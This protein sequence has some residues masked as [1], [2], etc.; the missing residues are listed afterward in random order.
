MSDFFLNETQA[1]LRKFMFGFS[2]EFEQKQIN[3]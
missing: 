3:E 1:Q 2:D